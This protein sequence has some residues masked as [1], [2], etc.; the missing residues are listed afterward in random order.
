MLTLAILLLATL[1]L[2]SYAKPWTRH[3]LSYLRRRLTTSAHIAAYIDGMEKIEPV[4]HGWAI[5][6]G[7]ASLPGDLPQRVAKLPRHLQR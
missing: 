7:T 3:V 2:F 4:V 6:R 5:A 1:A